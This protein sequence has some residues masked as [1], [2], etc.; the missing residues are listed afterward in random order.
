MTT[1]NLCPACRAEASERRRVLSPC[2]VAVPESVTVTV[3]PCLSVSLTPP[4]HG[5][6]PS[7]SNQT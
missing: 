3:R 2:L 6:T 4:L 5:F 7:P 1:A